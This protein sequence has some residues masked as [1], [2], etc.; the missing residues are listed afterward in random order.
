MTW[1]VNGP[2][3]DKDGTVKKGILEEIERLEP[4]IMC[5]QELSPQAF[6]ELKVSLDSTFSFTNSMAIKKE[7]YRYWIYSK[8][9]IRNFSQYKCI[10]EIDTIGFDNLQLK[11]I[12]D[13]KKKMPVYSA[14]IEV[15][16][17]QWITVFACHI[18]SS[19]YSTAHRSMEEGSSWI[20][21]ISLYLDN[22]KTGKI[23]RDYEADNL[24]SYLDSLEASDTP[25]IITGDFNDWS[26][27]YCMNT[28]RGNRY[29]DAWWEVGFGF[30]IT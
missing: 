13:L 17:D 6:K 22:Y 9:P 27:S 14:D 16:P 1:I 5:F 3:D 10:T 19:A 15:K 28:I 4:D 30:G 18:R 8:K 29:N 7:K 2:V 23:I 20:K 12:K 21:G 26:G 25:I 24:K 11:E